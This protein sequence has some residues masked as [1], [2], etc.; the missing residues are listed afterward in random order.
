[1]SETRLLAI[2]LIVGGVGLFLLSVAADLL[3]LGRDPGFGPWQMGGSVVGILAAIA[4]GI[5]YRKG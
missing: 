2:V 1:M 4:G 5:L 3:G